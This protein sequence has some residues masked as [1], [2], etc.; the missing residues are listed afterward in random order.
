LTLPWS[1]STARCSSITPLKKAGLR[2]CYPRASPNDKDIHASETFDLAL[3]G[4]PIGERTIP[5]CNDFR[6][7]A[8]ERI[9]VITGPNQGGKTTFAR[10]FG[11]L[12]Y[13]ASLG[14]PVPGAEAQL[15]LPDQIFTHFER[16]EHMTNLTG[17]LQDD[18]V[19]IHKVLEEATP[20][21]I[22]IIN[23][24]FT[25]TT[26]QD[27]VSLSQKVATTIMTM[28]ALC[29]WVTFIDEI[30]SL[31]EK[32]VSMVATVTPENPELRTFKLIR[33]PPNGL[34]YAMSIARKYR[35]TRDTI[36]ER[37]GS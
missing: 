25:S 36:K 10:T 29:T 12:H 4:K 31:S 1:A 18:L 33:Q 34:A 13:L 14:L 8:P 17:K 26:L 24:I 7:N 5:V 20:Q 30:A 21:S 15:Y 16:A 3:A 6:L 22:I 35:L 2:F 28:D 11:Q 23:E 19:R 32:T 9:I 27:A 37:I